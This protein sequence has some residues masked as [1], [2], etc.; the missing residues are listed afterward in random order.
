M[1]CRWIGAWILR[2]WLRMT[3]EENAPFGARAVEYADP[4]RAQRTLVKHYRLCYTIYI[5]NMREYDL[6]RISC[7]AAAAGI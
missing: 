2:L 6:G 3:N 4:Y 1:I 7:V 5:Y